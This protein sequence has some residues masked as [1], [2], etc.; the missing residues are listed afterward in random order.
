M[1]PTLAFLLGVLV[2]R[3]PFNQVQLA[4]FVIVWTAL[5]LFSVKG[6]WAHRQIP[7][8]PTLEIGRG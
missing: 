6:I 1:A 2:Y 5:V 7:S 3:E 8:R 4:G